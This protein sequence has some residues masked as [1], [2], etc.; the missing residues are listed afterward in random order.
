MTSQASDDK[1]KIA[2]IGAGSSYTPELVEGLL[3]RQ[4]ALPVG[5]LALMDVDPAR[6]EV[7]A[8]FLT[9][10]LRSRGAGIP[11]TT[12]ENRL[13]AIRDARFILVQIRVGGNRQ[14]ALD[15]KIP[16]KFGLVG[17]ETTGAGGMLKAFRTIPVLLAL[18]REVEQTN[19]QAWIVN[20]TNPTGMVTEAVTQATRAR[21]AGLCSGGLFPAWYASKAL[22]VPASAIGY[23][24]VGLNHLNFAYRFSVDGR[25]LSEAEFERVAE[26]AGRGAVD[27]ELIKTLR[28]VPSPY[29]QYFFHTTRW[30]DG[31]R[32]RG[33]TRAEQVLQL[34]EEIFRSYADESTASLPEALKRRGGGGYS[35]V[36]LSLMEAIHRD[37]DREMIVN[38]PNKG[39]VQGLPDEAVVEIRCRVNAAGIQGLPVGEMP[40]AV[41]GLVAAVKNYEQ[42]A[43]QAA[44]TGSRE[45]A[46]LALLAHPLVREYEIARPLLDEMLE[47]NRP[48]LPQ[49]FS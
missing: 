43:I 21:I 34:E 46:L 2:V 20:Y 38:V 18:A 14:R 30:V 1:M 39:A 33:Q 24:Y 27:P 37:L 12:T 35:E 15:E 45:T 42:L 25:P 40:G 13:E 17:Q 36:A 16:L 8:G 29:L 10:F 9:R 41:W 7:M 3:Q 31:A 49:F 6:L 19:P 26:V 47:A 28:M 5:E 44:Q 23:D 22:S 11:I 48:F 4:A 32:E